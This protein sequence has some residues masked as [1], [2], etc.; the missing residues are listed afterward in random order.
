MSNLAIDS[1]L[2]KRFD[3]VQLL[4]STRGYLLLIFSVL[5]LIGPVFGH[6]D[7]V[8]AVFSWSVLFL[9]AALSCITLVS[10]NQIKNKVEISIRGSS[11]QSNYEISNIETLE[12]RLRIFISISRCFIPPLFQLKIKIHFKQKGVLTSEHRLTGRVDEDSLIFEDLLFPHRGDWIAESFSVSFGDNLG[13][14]LLKWEVSSGAAL[15]AI[16]VRIPEISTDS[17]PVITSCQ[18]PGDILSDQSERQGDPYDLKPYHPSDGVRK[19][20]WK[21]YAK[22]GELISRHPERAMTP[23]GQVAVFCMAGKSEDRICSALMNYLKILSDLNLDLFVGCQGGRS[24]PMGISIPSAEELLI[25]SVWDSE[26]V[27]LNSLRFDLTNFI[28]LVRIKLAGSTLQR[29]LI[30]CSP[31]MLKDSEAFGRIKDSMEI[32]SR[33]Q[34]EPVF[35]IFSPLNERQALRGSGS[36]RSMGSKLKRLLYLEGNSAQELDLTNFKPF[37]QFCAQ[38]NWEVIME[39]SKF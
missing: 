22:K 38:R 19:I 18:R 27:S 7:I 34:I 9:I 21:V 13:F 14:S 5:L 8:A 26:P 6:A 25:D 1:R 30:F 20:L 35:F 37:L 24:R 33:Q 23:E 28:D 29:L 39:Q 17:L 10:A 16:R 12:K 36:A 31:L 32:L 11:A 3:G 4:V 15:A 2:E